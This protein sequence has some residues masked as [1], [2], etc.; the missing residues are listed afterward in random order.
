MI[1]SGTMVAAL[2]NAG[3]AALIRSLYADGNVGIPLLPGTPYG[4]C[5]T[6]RSGASATTVCAP[7][8]P[9]GTYK[10]LVTGLYAIAPSDSARPIL[11]SG[12]GLWWL[13]F[14]GIDDVLETADLA[15]AQSWAAAAA[16]QFANLSGTAAVIDADRSNSSTRY[17][18][19][20]RRS[21]AAA[22]TI[23]FDASK[24]AFTDS[25]GTVVSGAPQ[26]M[27]ANR[28]PSSVEG[29]LGGVSNGATATTG[30][31][32]APVAPIRFGASRA[33]TGA[34]LTAFLA[35][36]IYGALTLGREFAT[37]E[38]ASVEAYLRTKAGV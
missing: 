22:Q 27:S 21:S 32:A 36:R 7:G 13:A 33:G 31:P 29:W 17:A 14:D 30:T 10:C 18:Q 16:V 15:L 8:D 11:S 38:R 4:V 20:L 6:E 23:A 12:S 19:F 1:P 37:G 34:S 35:G 2:L 3:A 9:V 25:F 26:I 28:G 24:N 5:Y